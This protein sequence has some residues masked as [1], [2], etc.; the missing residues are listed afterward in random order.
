MPSTVC[1]HCSATVGPYD[2]K[3]GACGKGLSGR[4]LLA[5]SSDAQA[6]ASSPMRNFGVVLCVLGLVV[7]AYFLVAFDTSVEVPGNDGRR[8]NNLGLMA[9]RQNGL[10]VSVGAVIVGALFIVGASIAKR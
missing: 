10:I 3:C 2:Q 7:A 9:D 6:T 4:A 1:P 5:T 8:V